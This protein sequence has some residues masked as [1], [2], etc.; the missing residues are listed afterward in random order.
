MYGGNEKYDRGHQEIIENLSFILWRCSLMKKSNVI[1]YT[2]DEFKA[3]CEKLFDGNAWIE[4]DSG[5][6]FFVMTE[7]VD[8]NTVMDKLEAELIKELGVLDKIYVDTTN[9]AVIVSYN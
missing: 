6:W 7:E 9:D 3:L 4:Y 1:I 2:M 8:G 5:G